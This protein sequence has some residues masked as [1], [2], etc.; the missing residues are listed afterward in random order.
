MHVSSMYLLHTRTYI[1][2]IHILH[3]SAKIIV[4]FYKKLHIISGGATWV[5]KGAIAPFI[6]FK[7]FSI[8]GY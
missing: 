5:Q 7:V 6:F 8:L 4:S 2:V 3:T 1:L